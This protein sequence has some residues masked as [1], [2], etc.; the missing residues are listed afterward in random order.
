MSE[1]KVKINGEFC[2]TIHELVD[3]GKTLECFAPCNSVGNATAGADS[4]ARTYKGDATVGDRGA[5]RTREGDATVGNYSASRARDGNATAG[6]DSAACTQDGNATAGNDSAARTYK[7][8]ATVGDRGAARTR[9]GDATVGKRG[10]AMGSTVTLGDN[11]IGVIVDENGDIVKICINSTNAKNLTVD[12]RT[13]GNVEEYKQ[14][15]RI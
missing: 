6:N 9:E 14:E 10:V 4:A 11:S 3:S 1:K 15:E 12:I 8:D 13:A 7:G 2:G 5:A